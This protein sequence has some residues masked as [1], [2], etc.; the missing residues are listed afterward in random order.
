MKILVP[1]DFSKLSN[2]ASHYAAKMANKLN[3]EVVLIHVVH[4]NSPP[5]AQVALR[6]K[7]IEDKMVDNAKQDCIQLANE[8]KSEF[9]A[10]E[11]SYKIIKGFPVEDVIENYAVHNRI[12]FIVM[13]TKGASGLQKVLIGSN[14]AAVITSSSIP[15]IIVPEHA[16]FNGIEKIVYASDVDK[17]ETELNMLIKF[18][19]LFGAAIHLIHVL[20]PASEN[21]IDVLKMEVDIKKKFKYPSISVQIILNDDILYGINEYVADQKADMIAMFTQRHSF[22][23]KLFGMSITRQMAFHTW[24]PMLS[25]K[26][27]HG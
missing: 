22:F 23:D 10:P 25:I 18:A 3:A 16:R 1:T 12:D 24:T 9:S 11:V 17:T 21:K 7:E 6:V 4:L 14:A 20:P 8:L 26:K 13:G 2:T 19:E 5:R 15:V 27:T